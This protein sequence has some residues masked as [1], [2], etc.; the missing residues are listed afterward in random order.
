MLPDRKITGI[1]EKGLRYAT[2]LFLLYVLTGI[3]KGGEMRLFIPYITAL[4]L[5]VYLA[6][7]KDYSVLRSFLFISLAGYVVVSYCLVFYSFA[8]M[9]S[10]EALDREVLPGLV[11]FA[12]LHVQSDSQEKLKGLLRVCV[13]ALVLLVAGGYGTYIRLN[14]DEEGFKPLLPNI[15]FLKFKLHHNV[16]A[17]KVNFLLPFACAFS[18]FLRTKRG[19]YVLWC[20]IALAAVAVILSLSRGGWLSLFATFGAYSLYLS[21]GRMK[22]PRAVA[23]VVL[24]LGVSC[25]IAWFAFPTVRERILGTSLEQLRTVTYRTEIWQHSLSAVKE[26]PVVGWGYGDRIVW[27]GVPATTDDTGEETVPEIFRIGTHNTVLFVLFHQGIVGLAFYLLFI[28]AGSMQLARV[29]LRDKDR[30]RSILAFSLLV[31]FLCVYI[32]HSV[33]ET[34]PFV[35]PCIVFGILSGMR[36]GMDR[37]QAPTCLS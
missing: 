2:Y 15:A 10:L 8:P 22:L 16:Y 13:A 17:M 1:V 33:I 31:V 34:L 4:F 3:K 7:R 18:M 5:I 24:V 29:L 20:I 9:V 14:W 32:L 35:F 12:A 30:P 11:L 25:A 36:Q 27:H 26:S 23:A 21:R 19:K 28:V 6:V 37:E